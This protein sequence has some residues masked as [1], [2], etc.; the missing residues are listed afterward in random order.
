MGNQQRTGEQQEVKELKR[1][2]A[3][4]YLKKRMGQKPPIY[5]I[6][7]AGRAIPGSFSTGVHFMTKTNG[8]GY[9]AAKLN[10]FL[11]GFEK[12]DAEIAD[13]KRSAAEDIK[14]VKQEQKDL[15]GRAEAA[16]FPLKAFKALLKARQKDR[17]KDAIR[18]ALPED[19]RDDYT[20]M[21]EDLGQLADTPL[22]AAAVKAVE[23]PAGEEPAPAPAAK[24]T[25][26]PKG[27]SKA[28]AE[29]AGEGV[30]DD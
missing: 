24:K 18:N 15:L 17:E 26:K 8:N 22:G 16:G 4:G 27:K 30:L 12:L 7:R 1:N 5:L 19:L 11:E 20:R 29:P 23:P 9:D 28:P 25:A 2:K 10:E 14:E 21:V 13:I 6:N 3:Q